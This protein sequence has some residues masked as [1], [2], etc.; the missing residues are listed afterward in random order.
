MAI[1][2]GRDENDE[3]AAKTLAVAN[4]AASTSYTAAYRHTPFLS[5]VSGEDILD[6]QE[7]AQSKDGSQSK[8]GYNKDHPR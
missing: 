3:R 4:A 2:L 8:R 6:A 5:S 1:V 7:E